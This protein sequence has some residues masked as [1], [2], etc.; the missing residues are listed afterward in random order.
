MVDEL[1]FVAADTLMAVWV[2]LEPRFSAGLPQPLFTAAKVGLDRS[3]D[4]VVI[5]NWVAESRTRPF[6]VRYRSRRTRCTQQ[7]PR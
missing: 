4:T 2:K 5:E 7:P 1:F 3:G 6:V